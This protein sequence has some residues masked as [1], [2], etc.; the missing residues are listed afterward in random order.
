MKIINTELTGVLIIEPDVFFDDRGYFFEAYHKN[1]YLEAGI[2][3][4]FVQDNLSKSQQNTL[5]G[6]HYQTGD[7]SQG[8]LCSVIL[9]SVLDVAVDIRFGSPTFGKH[10][11][12]ELS[13][14]N[15]KQIW[16]PPGFAHGFVVKSETAVFSYKCT[17][18]YNKESERSVIY[19]DPILNINWETENPLL[20][21]KDKKAIFFK[22][23]EKDF[24]F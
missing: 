21:E 10:V 12:V 9:G 15:K 24:I 2:D 18:V 13:D 1:K 19:N 3:L 4:S 14:T 7:F 11:K 5:R 23:I 6:L 17:A 20:S 16:I 8:K 22:D